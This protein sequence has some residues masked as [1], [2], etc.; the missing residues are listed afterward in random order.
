[1][2]DAYSVTVWDCRNA[3]HL[4]ST[5]VILTYVIN[6]TCNIIFIAFWQPRRLD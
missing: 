5:V 6:V 1:M 4:L 2:L 3:R